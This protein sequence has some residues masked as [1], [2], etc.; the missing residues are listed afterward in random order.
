MKSSFSIEEALR[1][2][3]AKT[4]AHSGLMFQVMLTLFAVQVAG[5]IV[6]KVLHNTIEGA[7]ATVA[8][9]LVSVV[10]GVG[11]MYISLKLARGEH[12]SYRDIVPPTKMV[13]HYFCAS[14]L[15]GVLI[16][17][18]FILLIIPGI[19][20]ALRYSMVRYL[21]IDGVG[22]TDSLRKSAAMTDG[23]KWKLLG[24]L[25]VVVLVN[26]AGALLFIVGLLITIP[27][28]VIAYAH[29]YQKLNSRVESRA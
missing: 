17:V 15:T 18:G 13:W 11:L 9:T 28:T 5:S 22:I 8:L 26:I 4:R 7:L 24:F 21:I 25:G 16:V 27:T 19:Y 10:V 14:V 20:L 6:D 29:V 23:M 1:F 2:G 12:A 3:W